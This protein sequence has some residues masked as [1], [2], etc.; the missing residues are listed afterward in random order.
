MQYQFGWIGSGATLLLVAMALSACGGNGPS[1]DSNAVGAG[2]ASTAPAGKWNPLD[3]CATLGKDKASAATGSTATKATLG[4]VVHGTDATAAFS[5][6]TVDFDNGSKLT[7]LV[8]ESPVSDGIDGAIDAARTVG[9]TQPPATDVPGLG[10]AGL[11][12]EPMKTLQV[13]LDDKRYASITYYNLPT[14]V[15][16]QEQAIA[17]AKALK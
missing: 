14:G 1:A 3:A 5:M 7:L 8:R 10:R 6:C 15:T 13:F 16:G 2:Q 9:G 12:T 4:T 17:V 11:W